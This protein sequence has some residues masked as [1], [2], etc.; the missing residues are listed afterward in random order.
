M[1]PRAR[2][3]SRRR[4]LAPWPRGRDGV[5][6]LAARR[7][8]CRVHACPPEPPAD[9]F[10][11]RHQSQACW[12]RNSARYRHSPTIL[13]PRSS[14]TSS[15]TWPLRSPTFHGDSNATSQDP[16]GR[17]GSARCSSWSPRMEGVLRGYAGYATALDAA[18]PARRPHLFVR[19]LW[20]DVADGGTRSAAAPMQTRKFTHPAPHAPNDVHA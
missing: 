8:L 10:L 7:R 11:T 16:A 5:R 15:T 14:Q 12:V 18:P 19:T 13:A 6:G 1:F 17:A 3:C 9:N 20:C 4:E 2:A